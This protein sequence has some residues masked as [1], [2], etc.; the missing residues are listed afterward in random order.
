MMKPI[1]LDTFPLTVISL[2]KDE[3]HGDLDVDIDLSLSKDELCSKEHAFSF[4]RKLHFNKFSSELLLKVCNNSLDNYLM[5]NIIIDKS[6]RLE[7]SKGIRFLSEILKGI[8]YVL[9]KDLQVPYVLL[10]DIDVLVSSYIELVKAAYILEKEECELFSFRLLAHPFK[11]MATNCKGDTFQ[12]DLYPHPMWIRRQVASNEDVFQTRNFRILDNLKIPVP[13]PP[14]DFYI[15]A[16]HAWSHLALSLAEVLYL[17]K[18]SKSLNESD[19]FSIIKLA[20]EWGT[21]DSI[22]VIS[23]ILN[24]LSENLYGYRVVPDNTLKELERIH[25]ASNEAKKWL[26]GVQKLDF[27]LIFPTYLSSFYSSLYSFRALRR[28]GFMKAIYGVLSIYLSYF[29]SKIS[30]GENI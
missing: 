12:I 4:I 28:K 14:M 8:D 9:I 18:I 21:A 1:G 13:A 25:K 19:W 20:Y 3:Y 29:A 30:K 24:I 23:L 26:K 5:N 15:I 27:P 10:S 17:L 6:K 22:F 16:T 7:R 2:I 11:I